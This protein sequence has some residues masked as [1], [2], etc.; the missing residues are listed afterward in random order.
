M[1]RYRTAGHRPQRDDEGQE[2]GEFLPKAGNI[3]IGDIL[4]GFMPKY[5]TNTSAR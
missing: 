3:A 1:T 5:Y 4:H 2:K